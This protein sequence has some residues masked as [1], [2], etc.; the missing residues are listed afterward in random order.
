MTDTLTIGQVAT[1]TGLT[2]HAL[3]YFEDEDMLLRSIP[4]SASGRR[5]FAAQDVDWLLLCNRFRASGMPIATIAA[6]ADLVRRGPGNEMQ[7]L[8]LLRAHEQ[9][10]RSKITALKSDLAVISAKVHAYEEHLDADNP[11][12]LWNPSQ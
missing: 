8:E 12:D 7:R 11:G 5:Q 10:V 4:R 1:A 6:F 9:E 3:R 2:V